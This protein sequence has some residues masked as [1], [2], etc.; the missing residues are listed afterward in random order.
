MKKKLKYTFLFK[1]YSVLKVQ[2]SAMLLLK[3]AQ[4]SRF[5]CDAVGG[6]LSTRKSTILLHNDD[7][8]S[9]H[10]LHNLKCPLFMLPSTLGFLSF[11]GNTD[12]TKNIRFSKIF[13]ST[14]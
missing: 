8:L 3:I 11:H 4:S 5:S 9:L 14:E 10:G 13:E 6:L 2:F 12:F 1:I 7:G